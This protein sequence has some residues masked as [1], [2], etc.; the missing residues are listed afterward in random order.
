[1]L[2]ANPSPTSKHKATLEMLS[3]IVDE[4]KNMHIEGMTSGK[5][6]DDV[7][8]DIISDFLGSEHTTVSGLLGVATALLAQ[9]EL[10][11]EIQLAKKQ[12]SREQLADMLRAAVATQKGEDKQ[13][14]KPEGYPLP[15]KMTDGYL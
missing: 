12:M 9:M 10:M 6:P 1:M 8:D 11:A 5:T 3:G 7:V 14:N 13:E 15:T 4:V 2:L